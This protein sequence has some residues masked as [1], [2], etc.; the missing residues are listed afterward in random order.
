MV[1]KVSGSDEGRSGSRSVGACAGGL[2]TVGH[3]DGACILLDEVDGCGVLVLMKK[4]ETVEEVYG[5]SF[6]SPSCEYAFGR[7]VSNHQ[8]TEH[9]AVDGDVAARGISQETSHVVAATGDGGVDDTVSDEV[10]AAV[11]R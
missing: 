2:V 6:F 8:A 9:T 3:R 5:S 4:E 11:S 7:A 10:G 1:A